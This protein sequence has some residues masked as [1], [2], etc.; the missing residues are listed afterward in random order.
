MS[1]EQQNIAAFPQEPYTEREGM[2]L[3]DYH[4]AHAPANPPEWWNPNMRAKP[5]G[6][7]IP[8]LHFTEE[9]RQW[10]EQYRNDESGEWCDKDPEWIDPS[11]PPNIPDSFKEEVKEYI[12]RWNKNYEDI[13][14]WEKEEQYE[15]MVQWPYYYA[16]QML[17]R[18]KACMGD[19]KHIVSTKQPQQ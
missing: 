10:F 17:K 11:N 15:R 14:Q 3:L 6:M 1:L 2:T 7:L 9:K 18:R 12:D 8:R 19:L 4:A 13:Q 16:T 5:N